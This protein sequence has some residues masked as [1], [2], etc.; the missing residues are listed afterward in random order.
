MSERSGRTGDLPPPPGSSF[1]SD[2]AAGV[3]PA[4]MDALVAANE[5]PALAYGVDRWTDSA[6]D[7][8]RDAFGRPVEV[9]MC[10]GGT[11][12]NVVGLA[13][14]LRPWE[15]VI[16]PDSAHIVTDEAG[17]PARFTGAT[18]VPVPHDDGKLRPEAVEPF[19]H[20]A[21]DVHHPQPRVLSISQVTELGTVYTD[22][23]IA[24]LAELA[25]AHDLLLHLDGARI[26]NAL[27]AT[28]S[29]LRRSIV[30]V[31][32]DLMTFG[33][34]KDGAMYGDAVVYLRP[35]LATHAHAV[36]KQAGQLP[37]KARFVAAQISALLAD[38]L[39]LANAR[40]A[41]AMATRLAE[42]VA[43]IDGVVVP[44]APQ[45]N[46]VFAHLPAGAVAPLQEWSFFWPW[47][48]ATSL[49]RWMTGFT[50]TEDDVD[51]FAAGVEAVVAGQA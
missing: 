1:A 31:G 29:D 16:S 15:A 12:A 8:L 43:G 7:A 11:G 13:S 40:H 20:W 4:V 38:D 26:A 25:H 30:E 22:D 18:L 47:D 10:W 35:E 27:A 37:S 19:L 32:V 5:G 33:L 2:N 51:R 45:A 34:T 24:A 42:A 44:R 23:E 6:V 14:V 41:N 9:V 49:V 21:G 28:G 36:R 17:A 3:A 48:P 50:T 39:W 46:A